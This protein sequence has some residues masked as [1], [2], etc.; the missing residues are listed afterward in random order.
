MA[1]VTAPPGDLKALVRRLLPTAPVRTPPPRP[2]PTE[3]D[4]L[5]ERLLSEALAPPPTPPPTPPPQRNG[6]LAAA[7]AS[8]NAGSG[9]AVA[10]G[11]GSQILDYDSVFFL[12]QTRP[13]GG[14]VPGIG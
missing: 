9:I 5:L 8:G 2:V 3:M 13:Q 1:A 4:I 7:P 14:Q 10:D 6:N 11:S 12:W